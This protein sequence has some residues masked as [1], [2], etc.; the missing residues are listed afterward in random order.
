MPQIRP[1]TQQYSS[2]QDLGGRR[3]GAQGA[4]AVS[5]DFGTSGGDAGAGLVS[6]AAT[7]ND[8]A[9]RQE[10]TDVQA[11]LAKARADWTLNLQDRAQK[12]TPGDST[13]AETFNKDFGDYLNK[14]GDGIYTRA[15]QQAFQREASTLAAHF[16]EKAGAFQIQSAATKAKQDFT[17]TLN[18]SRVAVVNDPTQLNSVRDSII[19]ALRDPT[20]MYGKMNAHDRQAL[21]EQARRELSLSAVQATIMQNPNVALNQLEQGVFDNDIDADVKVGLMKESKVRIDEGIRKL[22]QETEAERQ[23]FLSD[24]VIDVHRNKAGYGAIE[25]AYKDGNIKPNERT[26]LTLY[27]DERIKKEQAEAAEMARVTAALG[28]GPFMDFRNSKDKEAVDKHFEKVFLPGLKNLP[29]E[30]A[31]DKAIQHSVQLGMMPERVKSMIRT[32]LRNGDASTVASVAQTVK[33]LQNSN[34]QIFNDFANYEEDVRL[35]NMVNSYVDSGLEPSLAVQRTKDALAVS[36]SDRKARE[37][38]YEIERGDSTKKRRESDTAWLTSRK[39]A[40]GSDPDVP[41]AMRNDFDNI[42]QLEFQRTGNLEASRR[43]AEQQVDRNWGRTKIG[44]TT[45]YM[46]YPPEKFYGLGVMSPEQNSK[47]IGQQLVDD[48]SGLAPMINAGS[49]AGDEKGHK[50]DPEKLLVMP[51][52]TR[53]K[54]GRPTYV[55]SFLGNDKIFYPVLDKAGKPMR[56]A[57]DWERSSER[58]RLAAEEVKR[59]SENAAKIEQARKIRTN[60][61]ETTKNPMGTLGVVGGVLPSSNT[62]AP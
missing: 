56:W 16:V 10:V 6:A 20:S 9:E 52:P 18:D 33:K 24:L 40:W 25:K 7:L 46:K 27:V 61:G 44:G 31:M 50:I 2:Q 17:N 51:D 54:N 36:A 23:R 1:Y 34:P 49:P 11:R 62:G 45:I 41:V 55:V 43:F 38:Q 47:W 57:P 26:Q 59:E 14:M 21:E 4:R 37:E 13:F 39:D 42:A 28:G 35:A 53:V 48:I 15:G 12:A 22:E 3:L 60:R 30:Q 58:A 8:V 5:S 19:N 29:P 32:G